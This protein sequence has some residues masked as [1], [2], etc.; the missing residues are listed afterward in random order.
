[1][2]IAIIGSEGQLGG[3]LKEALSSHDVQALTESDVDVIDEE[4]VR[5]AIIDAGPEW[6]INAAAMT[7]VDRCETED[8]KAFQVNALG[9][10]NVALAAQSVGAKIVMVSTDYVFDGKKGR[11]YLE[12]DPANPVNAYGITKLAGES[13]TRNLNPKHYVVRTS[14]L[15]GTHPC[16]GKGR[17][18]VETMLELAK[19][20][21]RLKIVDDEILTPTFA[22]DLALQIREMIASSPPHGT[23]HATNGGECSWFEFA[24]EIFAIADMD[25]GLERTTA[26]EWEAPAKR[27][28][29]SVLENA[30]LKLSGINSMGHWKDALRRYLSKKLG[31]ADQPE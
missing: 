4:C 25:I 3:D 23:Y 30:A 11:P 2:R 7:H 5:Q 1:M 21:D 31:L 17:N 8:L 19:E 26:A 18:F 24:E 20:K 28:A 6:V 22:E 15:Y 10:R 13:Y 29:Y 9:A 12:N 16:V 27:P 14:G